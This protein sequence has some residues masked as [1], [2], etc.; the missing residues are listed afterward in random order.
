M[1]TFLMPVITKEYNN[2]L[3]I[4]LDKFLYYN[5]NFIMWQ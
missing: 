1:E 3:D 5:E 4:D 2:V